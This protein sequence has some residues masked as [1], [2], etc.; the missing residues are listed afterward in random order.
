[1]G[2][3]LSEVATTRSD[4]MDAERRSVMLDERVRDL[5][6]QLDVA[7]AARRAMQEELQQLK[8]ELASA[9]EMNSVFIARYGELEQDGVV[10]SVRPTTLNL[11]AT[12]LNV[13]RGLDQ[14]LAEINVG[15]RDGIKEGWELMIARGAD[16]LANIR[17]IEV[18]I[19]RST[20]VIEL[21]DPKGRGS[22]QA[23]DRVLARAGG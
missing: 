7:V 17:I 11:D 5:M 1:M 16:F 19:N 14:T 6:G 8:G 4:A 22:V 12:V 13:R 2:Q 18:D 3:L 23:G 15:S 10:L 20:G 21:E 9:I